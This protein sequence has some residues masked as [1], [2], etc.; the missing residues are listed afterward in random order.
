VGGHDDGRA[1]AVDPVDQLHDPDGGLGVEVAG[2]L[3]GEQQGR[4]VDERPRDRDALLLTARQLVREVVEL[5]READEPQDVRHLAA[6]LLA[7]LA[8]HLQRVGDVVVDRA[9][10]QELVVLEHDADVAAQVGD[11]AARDLAQRAAGDRDL[12]LARLELFLEQADAGR[13][14]AA[15]RADQEHELAAADA[16]RGL[17]DR[18][19]AA[20]VDL[21]DIAELHHRHLGL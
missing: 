19:G 7:V 21:G 17:V 8:E 5:G 6:D 20:V 4:M 2:R 9:V 3:V 14:P 18:D 15:R 1:G 10:R 13:L 12:A 11:A 16:H